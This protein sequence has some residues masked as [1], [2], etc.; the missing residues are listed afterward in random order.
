MNILKHGN[1]YLKN[2]KLQEKKMYNNLDKIEGFDVISRQIQ[3]KHPSKFDIPIGSDP[4]QIIMCEKDKIRYVRIEQKSNYLTIQ[5]VEVYD[6]NG[7][8]IA[9]TNNSNY[10][11][12]Y[13]LT[14]GNCRTNYG[15]VGYP[16]STYMG[17]LTT[18]ECENKCT[19]D[20]NCTA[21]DIQMEGS[22]E[23][24]DP[25]C[26]NYK[27][28]SV[29]GN[30]DANVMCRIR[31]RK[32][33]TP[34]ATMSSQYENTNPYMA[35]NGNK[36]DS[37]SWPNS[38]STATDLGGWWELDLGK[39]IKVSKIVIYNRP[40]CC[41]DR[42]NGA[43]VS[44]Y[45]RKHNK[46]L[47]K[48]LN[49][50]RMQEINVMYDM[51][52]CGGPVL[53]KNM[54]D[55]DNLKYLQTIYNRQLQEYNKSVQNL[56]ENS[57]K[58]VEASNQSNNKF[59]NT[60]LKDSDGNY[61]Y[62]TGRGVWKNIPNDDIRITMLES[63]GCMGNSDT[64]SVVTPDKGQLY[65]FSNAPEGSMITVDGIPLIKGTDAISHQSCK[66]AGKNVYIT[67]PATIASGPTYQGCTTDSGE[68]Q[69]DLENTTFAQ[70][71]QRAADKGLN[72]FH[73]GI[74]SGSTGKCYMGGATSSNTSDGN[75]GNNN[76]V[77]WGGHLPPEWK[78]DI[79]FNV[80]SPGNEMSCINGNKSGV[81][82]QISKDCM[83]DE[84]CAAYVYREKESSG[85]TLGKGAWTQRGNPGGI[86]ASAS[87]TQYGEK[88]LGPGQDSYS[89]YTTTGANIQSLGKTYH[90]TDDLTSQ[91]YPSNM[92]NLTGGVN[93]FQSIVGYN[94]SGNDIKC[95]TL[96]SSETIESLKQKCID[97]T[98]C[99]GF[100]YNKLDNTYCLKNQN[101]WPRSNRQMDSNYDLYIR[102]PKVSNNNSCSKDVEYGSQDLIQGT[103]KGEYQ[104]VGNMSSD[105][106]CGLGT[107]SKRDT[108]AIVTQH[109]KLT[110]ILNKMYKEIVKLSSQ[111]SKLNKMLMN[112]YDL[113]KERLK[114]YDSI[115]NEIKSEKNRQFLNNAMEED[116]NIQMMSDN[117]K[118]TLWSILAIG[119]TIAAIKIMK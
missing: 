34:I 91:L 116:S 62:V 90:I 114:R 64:A 105:I 58:Y 17:K 89:I 77:R 9:L 36:S 27:D 42:L 26:Y 100:A 69:S 103:G 14:N 88:F 92:V 65:S 113:M 21:Y 7:K 109:K 84:N 75:C 78:Y 16:E 76:G 73:L 46:I 68:Y 13:K 96:G 67:E 33:G 80:D 56:I 71:Q 85:C 86:K 51:Q 2:R 28:P 29:T 52:R 50:N 60:F 107:I 22:T 47:T 30:N 111:D 4:G 43:E 1:T 39:N 55:Y 119:V 112:E 25:G 10:T 110:E 54:D 57:L 63:N 3:K 49:G 87:G 12:N 98:N 79:H 40:D 118:Y 38:A 6:E 8:N 31:E 37:Q 45:D 44:L 15:S 95:D 70:C 82:S 99:A 59:A 32:R 53:E 72:T 61:G 41:Q 117:Q 108:Q 115:Y 20:Q 19:Q 81:I 97:T 93:K 5:E 83:N 74:N 94:T 18:Q 66:F 35:I 11:D 23:G 48:T 24:L 104:Q 106:T 102:M 101:M